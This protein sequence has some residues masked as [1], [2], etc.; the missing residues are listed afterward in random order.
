MASSERFVLADTTLGEKN[1]RPKIALTLRFEQST[2]VGYILLVG[3]V[4]GADN[5]LQV[6]LYI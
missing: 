5:A 3:L 6:V 2:R 1:C 4:V